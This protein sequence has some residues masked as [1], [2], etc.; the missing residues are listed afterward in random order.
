MNTVTGVPL[1][2]IPRWA[3]LERALFA[4]LDQAWR[5]F[6][7][8]FCEPDGRVRYSGEMVG[9]DGVDDFYEPFFNWP[10]LY[11]LGGAADLLPAAKHHWEGITRQMTEFGFVRDEYELGYD[12][13]HQAE[14]LG[15]FLGLCG[16]DPSDQAFQARAERFAG[17]FLP[18][19]PT[20]NYNAEHRMIVAPHNGA[21]GPRWGVGESWLAYSA[22]QEGMRIYGL[23]LHDVPGINTW[24]DLR[25][26]GAAQAMGQAMH[27][28][29]GKGDT[30]ISIAATTL[31]T[32]A[33]LYSHGEAYA[34]WVMDY[35]D[36][37]RERAAA[38]G[39]VIPDTVGLSGQ[40]GEYHGGAWY[41][42]HYGWTWPHGAHSILPALLA[43]AV[44]CTVMDGNLERLDV[45]RSTLEALLKMGKVGSDIA[46]Q[47]SLGP[48]LAAQLGADETTQELLIPYRHGPN[49]WFD[50]HPVQAE[51]LLWPLWLSGGASDLD[52]LE[53]VRQASQTDWELVRWFENK[54]EQGHGT[55][56]IGFLSGRCPDYPEQAFA[57]AL[58]QV[59]RRL[60]LI[61][62]APDEPENLDIHFWQRL[63][64]VVTEVL[65]QLTTGAPAPLY[66]GGLTVAR[67]MYGDADAGRPGLPPDVAA[68]VSQVS[69]MTAAAQTA[70]PGGAPSTD[71]VTVELVN[72]GNQTRHVTVQAGAFAEDQI[73][74]AAYPSAT[75]TYPGDS[76]Q[77]DIPLVGTAPATI[78]VNAPRLSVELPP[79]AGTT[80]RLTVQR[81]THQA[82]HRTFGLNEVLS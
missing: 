28:R 57:M 19:S 21:G 43:A 10:M 51:W 38:N 2:A 40:V 12:W 34:A 17:F 46:H 55:P 48:G 79:R 36:A 75:G 52:R 27:Q 25:K 8:R 54:E 68:L 13:F 73:I 35:V 82:A 77:Y 7:A 23:P 78:T 24:E 26:P 70:V 69:A 6:E 11:R 67:V 33:W 64:P 22:D 72:T 30:A 37:W 42:G 59:T 49:G 56:W 9:R 76:H 1:R 32:N 5:I 53:R 16:A 50:W 61:D 45:A 74:S 4:Q 29:M 31:A 39:G 58:G 71:S 3:I 81:R 15:L 18:G 60:A 14:S 63:N 66:Y 80:L 44:N 47:G 62:A 20:G 41:G 65:T